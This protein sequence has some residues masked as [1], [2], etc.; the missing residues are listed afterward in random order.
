MHIR[1][2][3]F[4]ASLTVGFWDEDGGWV[5][6]IR[7]HYDRRRIHHGHTAL[8]TFYNLS[9]SGDT[10]SRLAKRFEQ[11]TY[12]RRFPGEGF[13]FIFSIGSNNS[14]VHGDGRLGSTMKDYRRDL[15]EIITKAKK[16][17]S[18][19]MFVGFPSVDETRTRPTAWADIHY[20]N[21]RLNKYENVMRSVCAKH[22]VHFVPLFDRFKTL[23]DKGEMYFVDGIHLND[24]GHQIIADSVLP[25][26]K[27]MLA[28]HLPENFD[29]L[30][31]SP[32]RKTL[33]SKLAGLSKDF[34]MRAGA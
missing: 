18:M 15:E 2:L 25:E 33:I 7:R 11:E 27:K 17:S 31:T 16:Y 9:I 5:H 3:V 23:A 10:S 4:G 24:H 13:A 29:E 12:N 1:V 14:Y 6:R 32:R 21:E 20:T 30:A 26:L 22:K 8:P 34:G 28:E 19:I